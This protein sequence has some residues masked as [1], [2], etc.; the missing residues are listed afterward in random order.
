MV[1]S[2]VYSLWLCNRIIF[3]NVKHKVKGC[4]Q[5]LKPYQYQRIKYTNY[6]L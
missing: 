1:L 3:G 5:H 6:L 4:K 2:A